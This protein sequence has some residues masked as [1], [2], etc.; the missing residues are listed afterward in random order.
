[1]PHLLLRLLLL[2]HLPRLLHI[3]PLL[4]SYTLL[5]LLILAILLLLLLFSSPT[6][7][8]LILLSPWVF[9]SQSTCRPLSGSSSES[10]EDESAKHFQGHTE[11]ITSF[12][13]DGDDG[14]SSA[15]PGS[16][17]APSSA[18]PGSSTNGG[19]GGGYKPPTASLAPAVRSQG[20]LDLCAGP[21]VSVEKGRGRRSVINASYSPYTPPTRLT[22]LL[23]V[24][25][26]S[27]PRAPPLNSPPMVL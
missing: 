5:Q 16:V 13:E 3:I 19:G 10:S 26:P 27:P 7:L 17:Q 11:F 25:H 9:N 14:C 22:H 21:G 2:F 24:L 23:P 6:L 20:L 1:M 8:L 18:A 4:P 15:Q 12:G